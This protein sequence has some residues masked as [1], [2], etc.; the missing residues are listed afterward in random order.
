MVKADVPAEPLHNFW[1]FKKG[2]AFDC[3]LKII[4][5][6]FAAP[7]GVLELMLNVKQVNSKRKSKEIG[8]QG[9]QKEV[10]GP[11]QKTE[12]SDNDCQGEI[13]QVNTPPFLLLGLFCV[14]RETVGNEEDC[15]R[16]DDEQGDWVAVEPVFKFIPRGQLVIFLNRH[17]INIPD[18]ARIQISGRGMVDGMISP[19]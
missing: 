9:D 8:G 18:P 16:T 14:Q 6:L 3:R 10:F 5:F 1:Q 4:P 7:V 15:D 12:T 11:D 17:C 2:S 13:G 19:P